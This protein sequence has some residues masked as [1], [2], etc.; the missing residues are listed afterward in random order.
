MVWSALISSEKGSFQEP[1]LADGFRYS[2]MLSALDMRRVIVNRSPCKDT[3][4]MRERQYG[5]RA[6]GHVEKCVA[7]RIARHALPL[8]NTCTYS[9]IYWEPR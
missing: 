9:F 1:K 7:G 5:P 2:S 8:R 3:N 6:D 4:Q